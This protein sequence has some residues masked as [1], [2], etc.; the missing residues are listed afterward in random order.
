G[1]SYYGGVS[2]DNVFAFA[3]R[4]N[5]VLKKNI[6]VEEKRFEF[7]RENTPWMSNRLAIIYKTT[8]ALRN[9]LPAD[10]FPVNTGGQ[11]FT[12]FEVALR[13]RFAYLERFV[14][15]HFYRTSL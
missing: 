15:S 10:S 13:F 12:N 3:V 14:E 5:G 2:A 9:L 1:Q 4:K 7:F 11:A 6:N 8:T